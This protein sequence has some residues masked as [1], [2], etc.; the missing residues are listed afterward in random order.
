VGRGLDSTCKLV[1]L[2]GS[3]EENR[4]LPRGYMAPS[5]PLPFQGPS[6][7]PV[8]PLGTLDVSTFEDKTVGMKME[9]A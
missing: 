8:A 4:N 5:F 9:E 3:L 6:W 7:E 2:C 1:A